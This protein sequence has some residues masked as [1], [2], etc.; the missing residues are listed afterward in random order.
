MRVGL[1]L[2]GTRAEVDRGTDDLLTSSSIDVSAEAEVRDFDL[3]SGR[4]DEAPKP[5]EVNR[6]ATDPNDAQLGRSSNSHAD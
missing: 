2:P 1:H 4:N 6:G 3:Y 5:G